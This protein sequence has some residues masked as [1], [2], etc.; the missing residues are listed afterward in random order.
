MSAF[1][2]RVRATA[3]AFAGAMACVVLVGA[4][5]AFAGAHEHE[6][7]NISIT[8]PDDWEVDKEG[9]MLFIRSDTVLA[10]VD[11]IA[12]TTL[13]SAQDLLGERLLAYASAIAPDRDWEETSLG[14]MQA[15]T[16]GGDALMVV[17]DGSQVPAVWLGL[18]INSNPD[19]PAIMSV[20]AEAG[21]WDVAEPDVRTLLAGVTALDP[22]RVGGG[23]VDEEDAHVGHI[24]Y[25][26]GK[27]KVR[28]S[29]LP[30][31]TDHLVSFLP[32]GLLLGNAQSGRVASGYID[33]AAGTFYFQGADDD[34]WWSLEGAC[35]ASL[36]ALA[37]EGTRIELPT[38]A[39]CTASPVSFELTFTGKGW[40]GCLDDGTDCVPLHIDPLTTD[41]GRRVSLAVDLHPSTADDGGALSYEG[42]LE[43]AVDVETGLL[44]LSWWNDTL[45]DGFVVQQLGDCTV[46]GSGRLNCAGWARA[47]DGNW[48]S[49]TSDFKLT[50]P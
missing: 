3:V 7:G 17:G 9:D 12:A 32:D 36:G 25:T 45:C 16:V 29:V 20:L 30:T 26:V 37:C 14:G 24:I 10:I 6:K 4:G 1:V 38:G 40:S 19:N 46:T 13:G 11:V 27:K 28:R 42:L 34:L 33:G 47:F 5:S 43:G 50:V 31:L 15:W 8:I 49:M 41:R 39:G 35:E 44:L 18:I 2:R 48:E 23:I 22:S 21:K